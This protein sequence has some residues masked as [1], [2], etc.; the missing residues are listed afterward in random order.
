MMA[1]TEAANVTNEA[2][3]AAD[4][5]AAIARAIP[6]EGV[7]NGV[8]YR[9]ESRTWYVGGKY[10]GQA[11]PFLLCEVADVVRSTTGH[12]YGEYQGTRFVDGALGLRN[13]VD[14]ETAMQAR[15]IHNAGY[16]P[17]RE[18]HGFPYPLADW[19]EMRIVTLGLADQPDATARAQ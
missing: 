19:G 10:L 12:Y 5:E 11:A 8:R 17:A 6:A 4:I 3:K 18:F 14:R 9:V 15:L 16:D 2:S 7:M 1:S 13:T